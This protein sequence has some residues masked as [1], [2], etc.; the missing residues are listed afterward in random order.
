MILEYLLNKPITFVYQHLADANKFVAVHPLIYKCE[1][2]GKNQFRFYEKQKLFG[3][4]PYRFSYIVQLNT[5]PKQQI[6]TMN[7][8]AMGIL[9]I[10]LIFQLSEKQGKTYI[11][12]TVNLKSV[13]PI[14]FL[15]NP[16]FS[17]VHKEI[18][19]RIENL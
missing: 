18:F 17:T 16:I 10:E 1:Q 9:K 8:V 2:V 12:E 11:K 3:F 6:V 4:L 19:E 14:V 15:V 5:D 7:A 13:L